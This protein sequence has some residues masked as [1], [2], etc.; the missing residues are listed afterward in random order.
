MSSL[1]KMNIIEDKGNSYRGVQTL[2]EIVP[3][4]LALVVMLACVFPTTVHSTPEDT[5]VKGEVIEE[6]YFEG[7]RYI[8]RILVREVIS[9]P[10]EEDYNMILEVSRI[11]VYISDDVRIFREDP[12]YVGDLVEVVAV[13]D[14]P[15]LYV[16]SARHHV[17]VIWEFALRVEMVEQSIISGGSVDYEVIVDLASGVARPVSLDVSGLP[18]GM[19]YSFTIP[20]EYP[21]FTSTLTITVTETMKAQTYNFLVIAM[22]K[23]KQQE[24]SATLVVEERPSVD[25]ASWLAVGTIVVVGGVYLLLKPEP[26]VKKLDKIKEKVEKIKKDIP[27]DVRVRYYIA[28]IA[29]ESE[30]PVKDFEVEVKVATP[31]LPPKLFASRIEENRA[32]L[33]NLEAGESAEEVKYI[34]VVPKLKVKPLAEV[35]PKVKEPSVVVHYS[36]DGERKEESLGPNTV[37]LSEE[38]I[39]ITHKLE[40][41]LGD[42]ISSLKGDID[43]IRNIVVNRKIKKPKVAYIIVLVLNSSEKDMSNVNV[44]IDKPNSVVLVG[45]PSKST[46]AV[47]SGGIWEARFIAIQPELEVTKILF[48]EVNMSVHYQLMG[49][50]EEASF[51]VGG[52]A[53]MPGVVIESKAY[54]LLD[55]KSLI[56]LIYQSIEETIRNITSLT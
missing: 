44:S 34:T 48:G 40:M 32:W 35:L 7:D 27:I 50:H 37:V 13:W 31:T 4:L 18:P 23:G 9:T 22:A 51:G 20:S 55:K 38:R 30:G 33:G 3:I 54:D 5:V 42:E 41:D 8:L 1:T 17:D 53:K 56:D 21:P 2:R 29:N 24:V 10:S 26:F 12:I 46:Q 16:S 49:K 14:I 36:V 43:A 25:W 6:P 11:T 19:G 47:E 52:K 28:T 45:E 39:R 15:N